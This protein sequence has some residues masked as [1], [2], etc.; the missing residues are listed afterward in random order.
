MGP[1]RPTA[2]VLAAGLALVGPVELAVAADTID[3][4]V[5]AGA[6]AIEASWHEQPSLRVNAGSVNPDDLRQRT[7]PVPHATAGA[8][9]WTPVDL[10]G[11]GGEDRSPSW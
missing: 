2:T 11:W 9:I 3:S 10:E 7:Q 4:H 1:S 8:A 5:H 6:G